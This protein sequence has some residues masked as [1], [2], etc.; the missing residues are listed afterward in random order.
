[1]VA[2]FVNGSGNP[3]RGHSIHDFHQVSAHL[4]KQFQCKSFLEIG[5]SETGIDCGTQVG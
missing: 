3:D 5:Q 2:M 4:A 1:M